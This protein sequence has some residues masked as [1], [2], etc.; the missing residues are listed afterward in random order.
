MKDMVRI[1][2]SQVAAHKNFQKHLY[3]FL[4][5]DLFNELTRSLH[6]IALQEP[7][8]PRHDVRTR[9]PRCCRKIVMERPCR[10]CYNILMQPFIQAPLI[11]GSLR[12]LSRNITRGIQS[13]AP[14]MQNDHLVP[15][16][17]RTI[18]SQ[19]H[20]FARLLKHRPSSPKTAPVT[21]E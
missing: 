17:K 21:Q 13:P 11:Q 12:K 18:A 1:Q 9:T 14:A 8:Q 7:T 3:L 6:Q 16:S 4:Q 19:S 15:N 2:E 5:K 10:G 20:R